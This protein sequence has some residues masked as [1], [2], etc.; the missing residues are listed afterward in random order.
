MLNWC[1]SVKG[2]SQWVFP[3]P[4]IGGHAEQSALRNQHAKSVNG[5][6]VEK[7][8]PYTLRHTC[9]TRWSAYMDPYTFAYLAGHE[10]FAT[11]KRYVYPHLDA[12]RAAMEKREV[13]RLR[14]I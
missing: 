11:T 9:L 1:K 12:V 6:D 10:D 7:F 8:V 2:E 3:A 5:A 13:Q 14:T 4:T